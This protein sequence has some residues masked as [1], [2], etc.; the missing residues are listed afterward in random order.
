MKKVWTYTKLTFLFVTSI[1]QTS[2][3]LEHRAR[4]APG[5]GAA[6]ASHHP[7]EPLE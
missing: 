7:G 5:R 3:A 1:S 6:R 2:E 4:A